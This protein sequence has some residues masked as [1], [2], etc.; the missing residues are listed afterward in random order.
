MV[1]CTRCGFQQN[2]MQAYCERC[3][4][5][6]P[7]LAVYNPVQPEYIIASQI[8][9]RPKQR[10]L[11]G[12]LTTAMMLNRCMREVIAIFG[13]LIAAFGL[14]GALNNLLG[15]TWA[16]LL[17]LALLVGGIFF[18][19]ILFFVRKLLPHLRCWQIL[20]GGVSATVLGFI[21]VIIASATTHAHTIAQNL[22]LGTSIFVY[23][24]VIAT[25]AVW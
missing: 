14:F 6:L 22:A 12:N 2:G 18:V 19:S 4:M 3:G 21:M 8:T 10:F 1:A 23:G 15:I 24:L 9:P 13:L 5:F 7:T 25:L 20:V 16:F 17:G 11:E